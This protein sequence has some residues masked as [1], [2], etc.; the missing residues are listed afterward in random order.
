MLLFNYCHFRILMYLSLLNK[1]I[2]D[3][4]ILHQITKCFSPTQYIFILC[5]ICIA[6][7]D[8][9]HLQFYYIFFCIS[10]ASKCIIMYHI[11]VKPAHTVTCI[12]RSP[13]SCP[14]IENFI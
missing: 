14:I 5:L 6:N 3:N 10:L 4:N 9:M 7:V 2:S 8:Q 13:F 11:I 1:F 12:K